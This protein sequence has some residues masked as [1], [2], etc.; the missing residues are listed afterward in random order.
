[1]LERK[2]STAP[3]LGFTDR[4]CRYLFR[5]IAPNAL[6]YT[7]MVTT[8]ALI[9]GDAARFLKHRPSEHPSAFQLGGSDPDELAAC[10]RM[11]EDSGFSEVNLNV[12]C[13][14]DRVQTGHMGACLMNTPELVA[15]CIDRMR[16]MVKIPVTVKCRIGIDDHDSYEFFSQFVN[17]VSEGGCLVFVVHARKAFLK[18]LSARQNRLIPPLRYDFVYR[19]KRDFPHLTFILNGGL[20]SMCQVRTVL[21][22]VDGIM[23]GREAYHNPN[24][25]AELDS[26]LFLKT[27]AET[28]DKPFNPYRVTEQY[29]Q[30]MREEMQQNVQLRHMARHLL[31]MFRGMPG[32]KEFRRQIGESI[33]QPSAGI[34]EIQ[35]AL[36]LFCRKNT[37][38]C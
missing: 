6:L 23:I 17:R 4:H 3:M 21:P 33:S 10:A 12:G 35:Q 37:L 16:S 36:A 29:M 34:E 31:V 28:P 20:T 24:F 25:L 15:D 9:H 26:I 14:S 11:A 5:L 38:S 32:V 13:P 2:L 7:E 27:A 1:M 22:E 18:G 19:I 30:Y 8:G